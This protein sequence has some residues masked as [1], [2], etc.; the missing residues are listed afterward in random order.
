MDLKN[1]LKALWDVYLDAY[2]AG[3]G[4]GC[5]SIFAEDALLISPYAPPTRGRAAIAA[6]HDEWTAEGGDDKVLDVIRF[7]GNSEGGWCLARYSEG[8]NGEAGHSLSTFERNAEGRLQLTI[9]SLN[10]DEP[11]A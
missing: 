3:D 9:C 7:G 5:A 1:E 6:L 8:D 2:R 4:A 10:D 11:S